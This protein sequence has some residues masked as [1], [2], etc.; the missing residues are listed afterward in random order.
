MWGNALIST[1]INIL[2]II[3][4]CVKEGGRGKEDRGRQR[5][6]TPKWE[7]LLSLGSKI[8]LINFFL[9][10]QNFYNGYNFYNFK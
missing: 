3:Y 6:G 2:M 5:N 10:F 1:S 4:V 9:F 7:S 8:F